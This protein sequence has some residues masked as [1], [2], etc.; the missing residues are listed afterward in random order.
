MP[1]IGMSRGKPDPEVLKHNCPEY[2]R[3]STLSAGE[4]FKLFGMPQKCIDIFSAYWPY[5]GSDIYTIDC[6]RYFLMEYGYFLN[7]AYLPKMRSH[8]LAN[9][10]EK[11]TRVLGCEFWLETDVTKILNKNGAVCGVETADGRKVEAMSTTPPNGTVRPP[12]T[13]S[14]LLSPPFPPSSSAVHTPTT[15]PDSTRRSLRQ[16]CRHAGH[17]I[18]TSELDDL[19]RKCENFK[20]WNT[21][22][23]ASSPTPPGCLPIFI[24]NVY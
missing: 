1:Y 24:D 17:G 14:V 4:A 18:C 23:G 20:V 12:V 13:W 11:R 9:N 5:Q 16:C 15:V 7:G 8:E 19:S 22:L 6:T 10:V 2:A 21:L 3:L